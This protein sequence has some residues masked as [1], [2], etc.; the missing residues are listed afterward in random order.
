MADETT[1]IRQVPRVSGIVGVVAVL[2]VVAAVIV[3]LS[4]TGSLN[5]RSTPLVVT[6]LSVVSTTIPALLAMAYSERAA[7]DIRNG[8]VREQVRRGSREAIRDEQ[9]ITRDGPVVTAELAALT[10]LLTANRISLDLN[11]AAIQADAKP[12]VERH[13]PPDP[14]TPA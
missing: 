7:R 3:A 6:L 1:T 13:G 4:I 9:V 10:E 11:T 2:S 8:V 14:Q 5:N 12:P